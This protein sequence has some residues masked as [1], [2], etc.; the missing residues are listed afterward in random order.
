MKQA[1]SD[2]VELLKNMPTKYKMFNFLLKMY[3]LSG[4]SK[5]HRFLSTKNIS[6]AIREDV[7]EI[8]KDDIDLIFKQ[9][10]RYKEIIGS[11]L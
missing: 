7:Q 1:H 5:L 3:R 4:I 11:L 2:K 8:G 9:M 6:T 10:D